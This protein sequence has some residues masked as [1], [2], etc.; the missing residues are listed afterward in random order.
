[1]IHLRKYPPLPKDI[2][3]I[4]A[5][6]D[7]FGLLANVQ[8]RSGSTQAARD[9][10]PVLNNF[11]D[12]VDFVREHNREPELSSPE[13]RSLA[14]RLRKYRESDDL[15]RRVSKYDHLGLLRPVSAPEPPAT[16]RLPAQEELRQEPSQPASLDDILASDTLGLLDDINF[17][18]FDLQHVKPEEGQD[19]RDVPDV[20]GRQRP[21]E[22][23]E[24]YKET[25]ENLHK[26]L[27]T[28]AVIR[29]SFKQE[30]TIR[31]GQFFLLRGQLCYIAER[32]QDGEYKGRDNPRLL[33]IFD[34]QTE[35][36]ILKLSLARALYA[37]KQSKWLDLSP[38]LLSDG[39]VQILPGSTRSGYIYILA[40]ESTAPE[41][42]HWKLQG[43]LVKIGF[44]T[45]SVEER[46]RN[47][48]KDRT[49]LCAPVKL[50]YVLECYNLDIQFFEK[51]IHAFLNDRRLGITM[52][53]NNGKRYHPEEWFTV[54]AKTA[55]DVARHIID[56][57]INRY[58]LDST[59]GTIKPLV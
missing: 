53:D 10:D 6:D 27:K 13:E 41:L 19:E 28:D 52:I 14:R 22:N 43:N 55:L 57:T 40:T 48:E 59:S 11:L 44:T 2:D 18:I 4:L 37:D 17:E 54:S 34:N 39:S 32:L 7:E 38:N 8:P 3:E 33:V 20:I 31:P 35:I 26:I 45:T 12:I 9:N 36:E 50:L 46:L 49:Y 15:C 25:F 51:I 42:A 1:M 21:C 24:N 58:R 5:Q 29:R 56:G 47:A 23:F 16:D 30:S